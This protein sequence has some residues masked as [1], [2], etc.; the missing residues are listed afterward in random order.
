MRLLTVEAWVQKYKEARLQ[1]IARLGAAVKAWGVA[2][3]TSTKAKEIVK[4]YKNRQ[5][6]SL[7]VTIEIVT[8]DGVQYKNHYWY[9]NGLLEYLKS[10][11]LG[12]VSKS[13]MALVKEHSEAA[14]IERIE[15][16]AALKLKGILAKVEKIIGPTIVGIQESFD[17]IIVE[18]ATGKFAKLKVIYAGGYNIQCLHI[19]VLVRE[20]E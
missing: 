5:Y 19:R 2:R 8:I 17:E 11:G 7:E 6:V 10:L 13:D 3:Q 4:D 18:G 20:L 12:D 15:K 16:E 1:Y 14:R 9:F